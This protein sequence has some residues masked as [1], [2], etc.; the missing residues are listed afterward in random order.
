MVNVNFMAEPKKLFDIKRPT[1]VAKIEKPKANSTVGF[2][3]PKNIPAQKIEPAKSK[4]AAPA[5]LFQTNGKSNF[6]VTAL[7]LAKWP[8]F[9]PQDI[10][11]I[12]ELVENIDLKD[13]IYVIKYGNDLS[14]KLAAS[15]DKM[16]MLVMPTADRDE[17]FNIATLVKNLIE[18]DPAVE[19]S[20]GMFSFMKKKKTLA[21]RVN[22]VVLEVAAFSHA[23]S[24]KVEKFFNAVPQLDELLNDCKKH[25]N[26]LAIVLAAGKEKISI[27]E[28]HNKFRLDEKLSSPNVLTVQNARDE[29][30]I[31]DNF[32]R[33]V[34]NL[35]LSVGQNELT[36]AQLRLTQ[37]SMIKTL[38]SLNNILSGLIPLWKQSLVASL[39]TGDFS[40]FC[41]NKDVL[42]QNLSDIITSKC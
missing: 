1:E 34:Q 12:K 31:F 9:K 21:E 7:E 3:S 17:I 24:L 23:I 16:L 14:S 41:K 29:L 30:N 36:I 10:V 40:T 27:F 38:E 18:F 8:S 35:E 15:V 11:K 4:L 5:P 26:E 19:P 25:H 20:V 13:R 32:I 28:K 37:S 2:F 42:S 39:S 22:E 6:D 33:Q